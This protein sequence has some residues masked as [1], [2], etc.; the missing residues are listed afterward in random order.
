[1]T[2]SWLFE[3]FHRQF[4]PLVL[5]NG[6]TTAIILLFIPFLPA[7]LVNRKDGEQAKG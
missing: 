3:F 4:A 1:M 2:G 7:V 5:L 6:G